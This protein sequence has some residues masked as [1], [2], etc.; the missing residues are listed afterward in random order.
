MWGVEE[1][2]EAVVA[3]GLHLAELHLVTER[4]KLRGLRETRDAG[5]RETRWR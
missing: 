2:V 4:P 1:G 3:P 5:R